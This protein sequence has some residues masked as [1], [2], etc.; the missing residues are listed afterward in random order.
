M[1]SGR[2]RSH[3][4][5]S[6]VLGLLSNTEGGKAAID[7]DQNRP[8]VAPRSGRSEIQFAGLYCPAYLGFVGRLLFLALLSGSASLPLTPAP[9]M[10]R[11]WTRALRDQQPDDAFAVVYRVGPQRLFFVAAQHENRSASLTFRLIGDAYASARFDTVIAEGF[12]TSWGPNPAR[13]VEYVAKNGEK[14]GFAEGGETVPTVLGA[15]RQGATLVGGEADDAEIKRQIFTQGFSGEDLLGFYV[16]RS[17]PQWIGERKITDAGDVRLSALVKRS[18]DH[19]RAALA[20]PPTTLPRYSDWAAWYQA[21]NGKLI[22][23]SF[24]T[25]EVGPLADGNYGTNRISLAV[26]RAR[27]IYL[28]N[29]IIDHLNKR[30]NVL[31]VFGG[32]HLMIHRPALDRVLGQP[33]YAG[34]ELRRSATPCRSSGT[35]HISS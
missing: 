25:E 8:I 23:S 20:L 30:E 19:N 2:G 18:L 35:Q 27:D 15:R 17:I 24:Q 1:G 7:A 26:S 11:P 12:P 32:S 29:L 10:L 28:H 22:S 4:S 21:N 6:L 34:I 3:C 14:N 16:L 31:V 5:R 33:C 13:I 9:E